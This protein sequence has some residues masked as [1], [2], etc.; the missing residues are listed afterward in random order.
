MVGTEES[1]RGRDSW[2][3]MRSE[4]ECPGLGVQNRGRK[5]PG[6]WSESRRKETR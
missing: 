5:E 2:S 3:R 6:M 1:G 4:D